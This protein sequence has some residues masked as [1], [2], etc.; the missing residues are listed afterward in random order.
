MT[1]FLRNTRMVLLAFEPFTRGF[2]YSHNLKIRKMLAFYSFFFSLCSFS[3]FFSLAFFFFAWRKKWIS[4]GKKRM[5]RNDPGPRRPDQLSQQLKR[6]YLAPPDGKLRERRKINCLLKT[7]TTLAHNKQVKW[8][9]W[10]WDSDL[11]QLRNK[12]NNGDLHPKVIM[13]WY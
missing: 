2:F 10:K 11:I 6:Q 12:N 4:E 1:Y 7:N 9:K 13:Q 5:Q 8:K 3:P